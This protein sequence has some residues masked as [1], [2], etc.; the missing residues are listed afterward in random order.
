[1]YIYIYIYILTLSVFCIACQ[2]FMLNTTRH[3]FN[4]CDI[5]S[6]TD[7][8]RTVYIYIYLYFYDFVNMK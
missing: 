5:L 8:L 3:F 6:F 4:I 1:M 2:I 7:L